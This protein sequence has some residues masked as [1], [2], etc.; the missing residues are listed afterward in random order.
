VNKEG[1]EPS[2]TYAGFSDK[3][4]STMED[5]MPKL[6]NAEQLQKMQDKADAISKLHQELQKDIQA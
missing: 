1:G 3:D 6:T 2:G 4:K 5:G